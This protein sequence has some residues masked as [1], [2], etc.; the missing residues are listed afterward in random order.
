MAVA[1]RSGLG[2]GVFTVLF[3][4]D[5]SERAD[6]DTVGANMGERRVVASR[7]LAVIVLGECRERTGGT[8][9]PPCASAHGSADISQLMSSSNVCVP[10]GSPACRPLAK[11][12]LRLGTVGESVDG[13]VMR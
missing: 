6:I 5:K 8:P 13:S 10:S 9:S 7:V 11:P 2:A 12:T 3:L 1:G 4:K